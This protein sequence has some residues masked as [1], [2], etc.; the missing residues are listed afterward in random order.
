MSGVMEETHMMS[1]MSSKNE[2]FWDGKLV[3]KNYFFKIDR[4]FSFDCARTHNQ[5]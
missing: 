2:K 3:E 5:M 1:V 4:K